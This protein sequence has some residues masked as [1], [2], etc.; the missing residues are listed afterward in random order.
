LN[1]MNE[2]EADTKEVHVGYLP[3]GLHLDGIGHGTGVLHRL[4]DF[5]HS[6]CFLHIRPNRRC[7]F[8]VLC[9]PRSDVHSARREDDA[10]S[11]TRLRHRRLP[12]T[13]LF[14]DTPA[15]LAYNQ[16][17]WRL[18]AHTILLPSLDLLFPSSSAMRVRIA[19]RLP[20]QPRFRQRPLGVCM[21]ANGVD[22]EISRGIEP[23]MGFPSRACCE[24]RR[25]CITHRAHT[26]ELV[27]RAA[28]VE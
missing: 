9:Q 27:N 10:P 25:N 11:M 23:E 28:S 22:K 12:F 8:N 19:H 15:T 24:H 20:F 2:I 1:V 3:N 6:S 16:R 5:W 13:L 4:G 17:P 21:P 7:A 14:A 18:V 26:V